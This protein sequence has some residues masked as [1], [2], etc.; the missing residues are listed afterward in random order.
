MSSNEPTDQPGGPSLE[1]DHQDDLKPPL[2]SRWPGDRNVAITI[3][4]RGMSGPVYCLSFGRSCPTSWNLL[5]GQ[6]PPRS[7]IARTRCLAVYEWR[8]LMLSKVLNLGETR[9][10]GVTSTFPES[11]R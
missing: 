2:L 7:L 11:K 9:D 4:R 3:E 6:Q 1:R 10:A 5:A 8:L